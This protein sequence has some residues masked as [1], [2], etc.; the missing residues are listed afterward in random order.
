MDVDFLQKHPRFTTA[1]GLAA[2][3]LLGIFSYS[4]GPS[5]SSEA[6]FLI[7]ILFV[8]WFANKQ[9]GILTAILC[10]ISW[11]LADTLSN[12]NPSHPYAP[13]WNPALKLALFLTAANMV[14]V[15]KEHLQREKEWDRTDYLTGAVN[16][17][18]FLE[19]AGLE[20]ERSRRYHHPFT[21]AYLDVDQLKTV[22]EHFGHHVGDLLL[23]WV[24]KT[25]RERTRATDILARVGEDEFALLLPE[26]Q[27][28]P[29]QLVIQR[30][31]KSLYDLAQKNEWPVTFSIGVV[32]FIV[33]PTS[34][35]EM[36]R[37]A[38]H[39]LFA[40]KNSGKNRVKHEI[41][42]AAPVSS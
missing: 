37:K 23:Q 3:A 22:N 18:S 30:I 7:P 11:T 1:L 29:A 9:A 39:L 28:E 2:V 26:T 16:K 31:Q 25:I 19:L 34:T 41:V 13:I 6:F 35:E 33:P 40:A 10:A 38:D 17:K 15:F 21:L 36:I 24:V 4:L 20:I 5:L 14:P 27:P 32:S 8:G 42:S 12:P